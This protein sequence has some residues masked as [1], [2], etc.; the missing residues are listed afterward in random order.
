MLTISKNFRRIQSV[1]W[2]CCLLALFGSTSVRHHHDQSD[3]EL[4]YVVEADGVPAGWMHVNVQRSPDTITTQVQW[5]LSLSR[6]GASVSTHRQGTFV[7]SKDHRPISL[8]VSGRSDDP[9][10]TTT[11]RYLDDAIE[12]ITG[13]RPPTVKPR[14]REDWLTPAQAGD[15]IRHHLQQEQNEF[16]LRHVDVLGTHEPVTTTYQRLDHAEVMDALDGNRYLTT[17]WELNHDSAPGI[18]TVEDITADGLTVRSQTEAGPV[19]LVMKLATRERALR[20]V[21]GPDLLKQSIVRP[22][23]RLSRP[24]SLKRLVV[25]LKSQSDQRISLPG[26]TSVQ[27]V[28]E[29]PAHQRI[30]IDLNNPQPIENE[31]DPTGANLAATGLLQKDDETVVQLAQKAVQDVGSNSRNRALAVHRFVYRFVRDK[32]LSVAFASAAEVAQSREGDCT[33]HAVLTAA[34]LR[35]VDIPSRLV[36]GLIYTERFADQRHVF[37][38]HMWTQAWV[39]DGWIDLDATQSEPFDAAH[40]ALNVSDGSDATVHSD[41]AALLPLIGHIEITIVEAQR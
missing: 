20:P 31:T 14:P 11:Y 16:A 28:E 37:A 26:R 40:I 8:K 4:W 2:A 25:D 24:R 7:E 22:D 27:Q 19:T 38:Y 12:V 18:T 10:A 35:A 36:T 15:A 21:V 17:R 33:E 5:K 30:T 9:D 6:G 13:S 32:S 29:R 39:D 23:R 3:Q 34:M 1:I 41:I